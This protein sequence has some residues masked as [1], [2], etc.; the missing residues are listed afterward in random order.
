MTASSLLAVAVALAMDAFAVAVAAGISLDRLTKR[1]VF[2]L[3]FHFGL[4]QALMPVIGWFA[5]LAIHGFIEAFD[6]WVAFGLLSFIGFR[7]IAGVFREQSA[8]MLTD[9]TKGWTLVIL[10]VATSIDAFAVGLTFAMIG[11][12]IAVPALVIGIV[13]AVLTV[14]GMCLGRKIG[15][16]WGKR[17]EV[18]GGLVLVLIGARIVFE[19]VT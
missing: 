2:R 19:H 8:P 5:G 10:S 15:I 11:S 16:L 4:F 7:M 9:P 17:V 1:R 13:A 14:V 18:I 6:H 3:G 12:T